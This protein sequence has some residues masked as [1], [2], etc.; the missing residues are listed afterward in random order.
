VN[1]LTKF[2]ARIVLNAAALYGAKTFFEGFSLAEGIIPLTVGAVALALIYTFLRPIVSLVTT[3][4]RWLT[5]GLFNIVISIFL[6]WLADFLL[7]IL[8]I[9]DLGTLFWASLLIALANSF[10]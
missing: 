10:F 5:F 2:I 8:T 1:S 6:L 9:N 7:A 3:P 4:L